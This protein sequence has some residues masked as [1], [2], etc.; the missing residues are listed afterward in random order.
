MKHSIALSLDAS[1]P[2]LPAQ[3]HDPELAVLESLY[4]SGQRADVLSQR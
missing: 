3:E 1:A 2:Q 4:A